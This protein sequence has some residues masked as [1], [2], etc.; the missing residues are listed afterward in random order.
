M[1]AKI[2]IPFVILIM[3]C[4]T[5]MASESWPL[6]EIGDYTTDASG[7]GVRIAVI[8]TGISTVS[9]SP[10][11]L[12][13]GKNYIDPSADT[14]DKVGHGTAVAGIIVGA[15]KQGLSGI[16]PDAVLVPLVC[17]TLGADGKNVIGSC[18]LWAQAICDAVDEFGCKV[19]NLSM[20]TAIDDDALRSAVAYAESCGVVVVSAVGNDNAYKAESL[21]YPAA[22]N[23]VLGVA[24]LNENGEVAAFSQRNASV[25]LCAPG[26]NLKVATIR[27]KTIS[28]FG[29][30]YAAPFV[31]G[32]AALLL[33]LQQD[34]KPAVVRRILC[35]SAKDLGAPGYDKDSGWGVIQVDTALQFAKQGVRFRDTA[36]DS[37]YCAAVRYVTDY[38]LFEGTSAAIFD[39]NGAMTRGMFAT[40]LG[41]LDER[42][43][44]LLSDK[45][46][47]FSD[48][49]SNAYYAKYITWAKETGIIKGVGGNMFEPERKITREEMAHILYNYLK[50][51]AED[52]KFDI[53]NTGSFTDRS[54]VSSWAVNSV[55]TI[56]RFGIINGLG[57]NTFAP[58]KTATRAEVS[59]MLNS[60]ICLQN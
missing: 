7:A 5:A 12:M 28:T 13:Q 17:S 43:Y 2:I 4:Q 30:S 11:R 22:Y 3:M 47:S 32:T 33:S 59:Q 36:E 34:L 44:G 57:N 8:D 42:S 55:D 18:A 31:S 38:G 14:E 37:W 21:Y 26:I 56:Y 15:E 48:V 54:S 39:P 46:P 58:K 52:I 24:A 10:E 25:A 60:F 45:A 53:A 49:N 50:Y 6:G 1:K 23:T 19:I 41:R 29:T 9:I 16:A 20:G 40:V 51:R 27:G 35:A